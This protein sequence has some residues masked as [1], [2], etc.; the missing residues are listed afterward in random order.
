MR[1]YGVSCEKMLYANEHFCG[2]L[3]DIWRK[4]GYQEY[5]LFVAKG[6]TS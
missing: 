1:F 6:Q 4:G 2:I 3:E 5:E